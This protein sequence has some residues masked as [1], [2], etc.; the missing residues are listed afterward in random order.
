MSL[1]SVGKSHHR[2]G[3]WARTM[4]LLTVGGGIGVCPSVNAQPSAVGQWSAVQ[5]WPYRAIHGH[6]LPTG[7]VMFWDSYV[8]ADNP[9][10]WDP[11]TGS[12]TTAARSGYNIFCTG[13]SFF[14]DGR[15]FVVG[16][17]VSDNVGLPHASLYD[18]FANSW[19]RLPNMNAGRW[20][21]TA[22]TLANGDVLVVAGTV[23]TTLGA[24][25]LPQVWQP[26]TGT[27]RNLT[28]AQ[29]QQPFY[30][31]MFLAPNGR[32]FSAGPSQTTRYLN[33]SGTGAWSYVGNSIYGTRNWGSAVMYEPGKVL[34]MGG[35][36][37]DFY[38]PSGS[39]LTP[40]STAETIDLNSD[41]PR[42]R[43]VASMAYARK[44]HNA[45][46]LPDGKVLVTGGS[47][48]TETATAFSSKPVYAP[49]MWDPATG[50]WTTL[51]SNRVFR[52]YHSI[53]LLLPD[54]RVVSAGG[55]FSAIAE[56]FSPP[57]LFKGARPTISSAP[58]GVK[59]GQTFFVGTPD[60]ASIKKV[61]WLRPSSVTHT[62][63]MSQRLSR[64][65]FSSE[66]G[67]LDV[68]APSSK[69][70][71]PPGHY[72]LFL[73]NGNGVPSVARMVRVADT[74]GPPREPDDLEARAGS[75]GKI[76]LEW[77]DDSSNEDGFKIERCAGSGCTAFV[78]IAQVGANAE[79]YADSGL[80]SK[81]IYRY[82]VRSYN[83]DGGSGYSN[84]DSAS[85]GLW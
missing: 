46:L 6:M 3:P 68:K 52:G 4:F 55:N 60:G 47:S 63:D 82:R 73:L 19:T 9:Q 18:P 22:I 45:T 80:M 43:S 11:T 29:L 61:T 38:A 53:A 70:S 41:T 7:K 71:C 20:Y 27:W 36:T 13:F 49:E 81:V 75:L 25:L 33:T 5:T 78:E 69:N 1:W 85:P 74:G 84:T 56:V 57:Y 42:W 15:L 79:S 44:Q 66:D 24:N 2:S 32:V 14:P 17:H 76:N 30:P 65:S 83:S 59:Y 37:G 72:M 34:I 16:G 51:A 31:Y 40:T 26:A 77:D 58:T 12:I 8:N 35:T 48:G 64:L 39:V 10:L 54:G 50:S 28:S 62:N 23:N 67:G 21:P